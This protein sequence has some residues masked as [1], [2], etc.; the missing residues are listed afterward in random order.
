[1]TK[2]QFSDTNFYYNVDRLCCKGDIMVEG[3][4]A[5]NAQ[6]TCC[7]SFRERRGDSARNAVLKPDANVDVD[8]HACNC[9]HNEDCKCQADYIGIRGSQA[10]QCQDTECIS[11][12]RK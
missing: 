12:C 5:T 11:F 2:L 10:C 3:T 1:M 9:V 4:G 6:G 7:A 8:C